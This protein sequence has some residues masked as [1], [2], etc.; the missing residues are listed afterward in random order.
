M[1]PILP[2]PDDELDRLD[3]LENWIDAQWPDAEGSYG[4][5]LLRHGPPALLAWLWQR[6]RSLGKLYIDHTGW[7]GTVIIWRLAMRWGSHARELPRWTWYRSG[8]HWPIHR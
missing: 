8:T 1:E 7:G 5:V 4:G 6:I 2:V 3:R